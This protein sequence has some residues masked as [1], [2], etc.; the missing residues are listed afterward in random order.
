M[1][2]GELRRALFELLIVSSVGGGLALA[3]L[4]TGAFWALLVVCPVTLACIWLIS[5]KVAR[6]NTQVLRAPPRKETCQ[7]GD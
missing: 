1:T 4:E 6:W 7:C 5:G 3:C 2:K